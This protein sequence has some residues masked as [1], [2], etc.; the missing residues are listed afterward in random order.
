MG[1]LTIDRS[2]YALMAV[3]RQ[4]GV[5]RWWGDG[6]RPLNMPGADPMA[7]DYRGA[8]YWRRVDDHSSIIVPIILEPTPAQIERGESVLW[9]EQ[10]SQRT[11]MSML[12][13]AREHGWGARLSRSRYLSAPV[14]SGAADRRGR[15]LEV[16]TV[17]LRLRNEP[18]GVVAGIAG[19]LT[20]EY[21]MERKAWKPMGGV[22]ADVVPGTMALRDVRSV[23]IT[24][25]QVIMGMK[26][27]GGRS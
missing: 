13:W 3:A 26:S 16:E 1:V 12:N 6:P 18:Q 25:M 23:A 9:I 5:K 19:A 24:Q 17:C 2:A 15:R 11:A 7:Q 8:A 14:N 27:E 20:W 4:A 10:T 21:D 22:V